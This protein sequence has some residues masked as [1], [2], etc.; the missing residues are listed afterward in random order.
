MRVH[1]DS[2]HNKKILSHREVASPTKIIEKS[3][4]GLSSSSNEQTIQFSINRKTNKIIFLLD[5]EKVF[6][7]IWQHVLVHKL[8]N[9]IIHYPHPCK[10]VLSFL[11]RRKSSCRCSLLKAT[12]LQLQKARASLLN[13]TNLN[14]LASLCFK[15]R[16]WRLYIISHS[17]F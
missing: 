2:I 10:L 13:S 11:K 9:I 14:H 4:P 1:L 5:I 8:N 17:L 12:Q 6:H 16:K 7:P 3:P 15:P